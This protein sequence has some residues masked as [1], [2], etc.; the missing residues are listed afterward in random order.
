MKYGLT[1]SMIVYEREFGCWH[2]KTGMRA[3]SLTGRVH[4]TLDLS[5]GETRPRHPR[6]LDGAPLGS[7]PGRMRRADLLE[8][9]GGPNP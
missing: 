9:P 5:E 4:S 8:S 6:F 2:S 3:V 1:G 7:D